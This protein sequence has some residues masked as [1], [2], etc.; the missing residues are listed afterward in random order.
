MID[1]I[2]LF[3]FCCHTT[4]LHCFI[5]GKKDKAAPMCSLAVIFTHFFSILVI[6]NAKAKSEKPMIKIC[7]L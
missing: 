7:Q 3:K 2:I 6:A 5:L 4:N 1:V